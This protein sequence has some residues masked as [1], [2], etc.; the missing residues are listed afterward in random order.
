MLDEIRVFLLCLPGCR[1]K[2]LLNLENLTCNLCGVHVE[3]RSVANAYDRWM[4]QDYQLCGKLCCNSWRIVNMP[5]HVSPCDVLLSYSADVESYVVSR[6]GNL[7]LLV[8]HLYCLH[9]SNNAFA[10]PSRYYYD[11][12][13]KLH[14][15]SFYSSNWNNSDSCDVVNVLDWQPQWKVCWLLRLLELVKLLP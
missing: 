12:V 3:D 6:F 1:V 2:L 10:F 15:S 13:V 11:L 7:Q 8:V 4:V 14:Y 9:F 5:K